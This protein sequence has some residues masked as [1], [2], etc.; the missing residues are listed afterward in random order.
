MIRRRIET[1]HA[2]SFWRTGV[3]CCHSD[4]RKNIIL[5]QSDKLIRIKITKKNMEVRLF[6]R[7]A[8]T[9]SSVKTTS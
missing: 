3:T 8:V 9:S 7:L 2:K 4:C 6:M 5:T 1:H